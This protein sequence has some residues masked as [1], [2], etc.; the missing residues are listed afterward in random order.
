MADVDIEAVLNRQRQ[1]DARQGR[2]GVVPQTGWSQQNVEDT[3]RVWGEAGSQLIDYVADAFTPPSDPRAIEAQ[4][5]AENLRASPQAQ[6]QAKRELDNDLTKLNIDIYGDKESL[7]ATRGAIA[8]AATMTYVASK[9]TEKYTQALNQHIANEYNLYNDTDYKAEDFKAQTIKGQI[10]WYDPKA[11]MRRLLNPRNFQVEDLVESGIEYGPLGVGLAA[12]AATLA[13][14]PLVATLAGAAGVG[15]AHFFRADK[16]LKL[17]GYE[18]KTDVTMDKSF[19]VHKG[20]PQKK[21]PLT[22]VVLDAAK[23]SG[24]WAVL[25]W[26]GGAGL[27]FMRNQIIKGAGGKASGVL[28]DKVN[29][30][31]FLDAMT[32]EMVRNRQT[33]QW[34]VPGA[35]GGV[36]GE[37][38]GEAGGVGGKVTT[39]F[40]ETAP[41]TASQA[42]FR[43]ADELLAQG[44]REASAR[45]MQ[46]ANKLLR[47]ET[48]APE[49]VARIAEQKS[50]LTGKIEPEAGMAINP[51]Y[52]VEELNGRWVIR[53]TQK[54][55]AAPDAVVP[56]EA[57]VRYEI[58]L[59]DRLKAESRLVPNL[60]VATHRNIVSEIDAIKAQEARQ[61]QVIQNEADLL[62][63]QEGFP[64]VGSATG[65]Q[66]AETAGRG[67]R[68]FGA[69][70]S[71]NNPE[72]AT[73]LGALEDSAAKT[74][75]AW[76]QIT[77]PALDAAG[78]PIS[79]ETQIAN[80]QPVLNSA[81]ETAR[82]ANDKLY[83]NI[84]RA[85]KAGPKKDGVSQRPNAREDI[86][87]DISKWNW[88]DLKPLF[89]GKSIEKGGFRV[90]PRIKGNIFTAFDKA[91]HGRVE[92]T[93]EL[94]A[95]LKQGVSSARHA[96]EARPHTKGRVTWEEL[97]NAIKQGGEL[98]NDSAFK[99]GTSRQVLTDV[100]NSLKGIRLKRLKEID[101]AGNTNLAAELEAADIAY[102][103]FVN[104]WK[105][106]V[107]S[108]LTQYQN[109]KLGFTAN[110]LATDFFPVGD[111]ARQKL[112]LEVVNENATTQEVA[113]NLFI[114]GLKQAALSS[115]ALSELRVIE[116]G[117]IAGGAPGIRLQLD[118]VKLAE[119]LSE[120]ETSFK[121]LFSEAEQ[122]EISNIGSSSAALIDQAT[123]FRDLVNHFE[124]RGIALTNED[125]V[126][127]TG[128]AVKAVEEGATF[129]KSLK[130]LIY[131]GTRE[132]VTR[133]AA[134]QTWNAIQYTGAQRLIFEDTAAL[135]TPTGVL[136]EIVDPTKIIE[137]IQANSGAFE[138]LVG[139]QQAQNVEELLRMWEGAFR[140]ERIGAGGPAERGAGEKFW[141]GVGYVVRPVFGVLNRRALIANTARQFVG[142]KLAD[143]YVEALMNPQKT[144]MWVRA[145]RA[146]KRGEDVTQLLAT[147]IGAEWFDEESEAYRTYLAPVPESDRELRETIYE[148]TIEKQRERKGIE[149]RRQPP[150]APAPPLSFLKEWD[151]RLRK[152]YPWLNQV[153]GALGTR[154]QDRPSPQ[155]ASGIA[156][157]QAAGYDDYDL[158]PRPGT[159]TPRN[160]YPA[161][162]AQWKAW[163]D[164]EASA[165]RGRSVSSSAGIGSLAGPE[166]LRNQEIS[167]L[168]RGFNKGGIVNAR[169]R[170]QIVL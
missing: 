29:E 44:N 134:D 45:V 132:G 94:L 71:E 86:G 117:E 169:P 12:G 109:K 8:K 89:T 60:D 47:D 10:T 167:K 156:S 164:E 146:A 99:E 65:R 28:L 39:P 121:G 37:F 21:I 98:F 74:R 159:K 15:G 16:G 54:D 97:D 66:A 40:T 3:R 55:G 149:P 135:R 120:R 64:A 84:G 130:R 61:L 141:Q 140:P 127:V 145:M 155:A 17:A 51:K 19:Y 100:V 112:I 153:S 137:N 118:P 80:A 126:G 163:Q 43:Y 113:R 77:A 83:T 104:T 139:K 81:F 75:A 78:Q 125:R 22:E 90:E 50:I 131:R 59:N 123:K 72:I 13:G 73:A 26:G 27:A 18:L 24:M 168:V 67:V 1:D 35:A 160:P 124:K 70:A 115:R 144:A 31:D 101:K 157:L 142:D 161:G 108:Q 136:Q 30:K 111:P 82:T 42:M 76:G 85:F 116:T 150:P 152:E 88:F 41:A 114:H 52:K 166:V 62:N 158:N 170:R 38:L 102:G 14:G 91:T 103:D 53:N 2:A 119:Y 143:K 148:Q 56:T 4:R 32:L 49:L 58:L 11:E 133:E 34:E 165:K 154:P 93:R 151:A 147:L 7:E 68:K 25:S 46:Q 57:T 33:G 105:E 92:Q 87:I 9:D 69:D 95:F 63:K 122:N 162:S 48:Q 23:Q 36:G 110:K 6:V 129:L 106:G 79:I 138:A 96:T 128:L 5:A 107:F 20:D